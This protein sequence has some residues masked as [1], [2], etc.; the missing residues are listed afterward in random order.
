MMEI[1]TSRIL[2]QNCLIP[3]NTR[4]THINNNDLI[5]GPSGAGKTRNYVKPNLLQCALQ[6]GESLVIADTKGSLIR[7]VG[8]VLAAH[9]YKVI[10]LDLTELMNNTVGYNP[11]DYVRYDSAHKKYNEQDIL[12]LAACLIPVETEKDPFW[13]HSAQL[14]LAALLGYALEALPQE[15]HNL[16]SVCRL[17]QVMEHKNFYKLFQEL[18]EENPHSFAVDTYRMTSGNNVADKTYA[19]IKMFMVKSLLPLSFDGPR[20]LYSQKER[21]DFRSLGRE[22][23]AIFLTISDTDRSMDKIAN[24][25]YTQ[26]LH[27]LIES[28][29]KDY[30]PDNRL[31]VPVRFILDDFATNVVIPDFDG[32]ISIIR[33]REVYVSLIIQSI[34]QLYALYGND[35][36]KTIINNCDNCLYLGGQDLDT[37]QFISVK[38]NKTQDT[39]SRLDPVMQGKAAMAMTQFMRDKNAPGLNYERLSSCRERTMSSI[40]VDR[41]FRTIL[42]WREEQQAYLF[43]Y[44]DQHDSAYDWAKKKKISIEDE[45]MTLQVYDVPDEPSEPAEN[46]LFSAGQYSDKSLRRLG[47]PEELLSL[48][49]SIQNDDQLVE[50]MDAFPAE[51]AERLFDLAAGTPLS[52]LLEEIGESKLASGGDPMKN[53]ETLRSFVIGPSAPA[54]RE[55]I[56]KDSLEQWRVFLHPAQR[57][58]VESSFSGPALVLGG[59]GTGKTITALHRAKALAARMIREKIQGRIL[60]TFYTVNLADDV[61]E[62]LRSICTAEE[63]SRI[64]VLNVDKLLQ[65]KTLPG[66]EQANILYSS[67]RLLK[68]LWEDAISIGDPQRTCPASFYQEEWERVIAEQEAFTLE[69][70]LKINRVGGGKPLMAKQREALWPVFAAYQ[71]LMDERRLFDYKTAMYRYRQAISEQVDVRYRHIIVDETQDFSSSDLRLLRTLAGPEREDDLFL[72]GDARQRIY[73]RRVSLSSCGI[74]VRGRIHRLWLNY[75]TTYELQTSAT[76]LLEDKSFDDLNGGPDSFPRY[77]SCTSGAPPQIGS[78]AREAE[79]IQWILSEIQQLLDCG[80]ST[81]NICLTAYTKNQVDYY[82]ERLNNGGVRTYRLKSKSDDRSLDGIRVGTMHRVKGLEFQYMF[83][84]GVNQGMFPPKISGQSKEI[85]K[86]SKCLLYVA[87]TR[88]QKGAYV[89]G[90]G[91]SQSEFLTALSEM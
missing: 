27:T 52:E 63:F 25:F 11:L 72:V 59:A 88:A 23:T 75:R 9:G 55:V 48:M 14:Y 47:V 51:V 65:L 7:E 86:Q 64:D 5:V 35:K 28:A 70:Y 15:E 74:R 89:C 29:D 43:L 80:V 76:Q 19:C 16:E 71:S 39:F 73:D 79:E 69:E 54:L 46:S 62:K 81:K 53:P 17:Y 57:R 21:I 32:I 42:S 67:D 66:Y 12:T 20:H 61:S 30:R 26:A 1:N 85:L 8:P 78:F 10:N 77:F 13:D 82:Q 34:N 37:S 33:S 36:G 44:V 56:L 68:R 83:V 18:V 58:L 40:R 3:N 22:Q 50:Q 84:A 45:T 6:G 31:P 91:T 41:G 60:Y 90:Y 24:V 38:A 87:L 49:R 4:L 2:A